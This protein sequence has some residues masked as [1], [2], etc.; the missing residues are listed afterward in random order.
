ML[1]LGWQAAA[2]GRALASAQTSIP[3]KT[4]SARSGHL[5]NSAKPLTALGLIYMEA[6]PLRQGMAMAKA[7]FQ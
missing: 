3:T 4:E 5:T 7:I 1:N 2:S 6:L